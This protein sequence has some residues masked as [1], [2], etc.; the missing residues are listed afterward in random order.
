MSQKSSLST[1]ES[2]LSPVFTS[3]FQARPHNNSDCFPRSGSGNRGLQHKSSTATY[4]TGP[5]DRPTTFSS[6]SPS[7]RSKRSDISSPSSNNHP[8][9]RVQYTIPEQHYTTIRPGDIVTCGPHGEYRGQFV[10]GRTCSQG[11]SSVMSSPSRGRHSLSSQSQQPSILDEASPPCPGETILD[12]AFQLGHIPGAE[13]YVPGQEKLSSIARFDALMRHAEEK[14]RKRDN[15]QQATQ[16]M[17]SGLG[18]DDTSDDNGTD[19]ASNDS[20]S[21]AN[22][23]ARGQNLGEQPGPPLMSP[24]AQRA[25]AYISGRHDGESQSPTSLRPGVSR[26]HVS[27]HADC[28][29]TSTIS[30]PPSRPHTA[31]AK[32]RPKAS[33]AQSTA[34]TMPTATT[35]PAPPS[36]GKGHDSGQPRCSTKAEKRHSNSSVK[37]LSFTELAKRLSST[38][39]LLLVQTNASGGSSHISSD[40]DSQPCSSA[41]RANLALRGTAPP[42]TRPRD[43]EDHDRDGR[44][45]G[46]V[47]VVG[48]EEGSS[49]LS[50]PMPGPAT[51]LVL[52]A[53]NYPPSSSA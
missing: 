17:T 23:H 8:S 49:F 3:P 41:P 26:N 12:R 35:A 21:D 44:R 13:S 25:L 6:D 4:S 39:S 46:S 34:Q 37:R 18:Q 28:A 30:L 16:T 1:T 15:V 22:S 31:H 27:F 42:P 48:P 43:R 14:R 29:R 38:S 33:R 19:A 2:P 45:R 40:V 9:P 52:Q 51:R 5:L 50:S 36:S 32:S 24:A 10:E 7:L 20:D 47:G 11:R 53:T